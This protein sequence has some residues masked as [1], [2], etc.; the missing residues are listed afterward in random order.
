MRFIH[1]SDWQLGMTRHFLTPAEQGRYSEARLAAVRS[2]A[3]LAR[4]EHCDF[5]VVSGDVFDSNQGDR[6]LV[7]RVLDAMAAFS[8]PVYLLPGNHDPLTA[9]GSVYD[10]ATFVNKCPS[11]VVVLRSYDPVSVP[12]IDVEIVGAPW[13]TK[14]PLEDLV[15]RTYIDLEP[16]PTRV[17]LG[18]GIVDVLSPDLENPALISLVKAEQAIQDGRIHYLALGDRHSVTDVGRTGRIWYSGTPL[19]TD[20]VENAPNQVL[21]V[22]I[23][24]NSISVEERQVGS[25]RFYAERFEVNGPEDV[26]TVARWFNELEDKRQ[27]VVKL[28]FVGTVDLATKTR[29]DDLLEDNRALVAALET[30]ERRT[31]LVVRPTDADFADMGF[32]GFVKMTLDELRALGVK[33]DSQS[34]MAQDALGLLFRLA[35]TDQ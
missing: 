32:T 3:A 25:W 6:Q 20:Y 13:E 12:G 9:A 11:N 21:L 10:S 24:G 1:T 35:R 22:Q 31:D 26:D 29:L 17:L 33:D 4:D 7:G 2:I 18:H 28:S 16:G 5:V 23:S 19:V 15:E 8:V 14:H 27:S 34:V 30:W